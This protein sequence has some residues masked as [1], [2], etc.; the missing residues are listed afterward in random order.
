V[1][2]LAAV[3]DEAPLVLVI[4]PAGYGKTA[5]LGQWADQDGRRFRWVQVDESDNVPTRLLRHIGG[6]MHRSR[7]P[8]GPTWPQT[9]EAR[10]CSSGR[11]SPAAQRRW[12]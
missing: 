2:T 11:R 5:L 12:R 1:R 4:A 7:P 10:G 6:A 9:T 8:V 3:A